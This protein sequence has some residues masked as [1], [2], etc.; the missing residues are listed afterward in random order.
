V[1][2][3]IGA[4]FAGFGVYMSAAMLGLMFAAAASLFRRSEQS[5]ASRMGAVGGYFVGFVLIA[6]VAIAMPFDIFVDNADA[7][8]GF[9][10]WLIVGGAVVG[11]IAFAI[12]T[13]TFRAALPR[14]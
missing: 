13:L 6:W 8:G 11:L 14:E 12:V 5:F 10:G 4:V 7:L 3:F 9:T 1:N 2:V